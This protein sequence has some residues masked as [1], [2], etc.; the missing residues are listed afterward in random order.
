MKYISI[1]F[2]F[3]SD[4]NPKVKREMKSLREKKQSVIKEVVASKTI[5]IKEIFCTVCFESEFD[6]VNSVN[7]FPLLSISR[8]ADTKPKI[9]PITMIQGY[10]ENK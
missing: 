9:R 7:Y 3:N 5:H 6:T 8:K 2:I 10:D 1:H 4:R